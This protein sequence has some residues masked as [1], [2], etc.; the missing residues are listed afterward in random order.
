MTKRSGRAVL[1]ASGLLLQVKRSCFFVGSYTTDSCDLGQET[2]VVDTVL[3]W[4]T[5]NGGS[6]HPWEE[7]ELPAHTWTELCAE[8][9]EEGVR[10]SK[11]KGKYLKDEPPTQGQSKVSRDQVASCS[12]QRG[13]FYAWKLEKLF[14]LLKTHINCLIAKRWQ[15][16]HLRFW[17]PRTERPS[18]ISSFNDATLEFLFTGK[19]LTFMSLQAP[20]ITLNY[21]EPGLTRLLAHACTCKSPADLATSSNFGP[22]SMPS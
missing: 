3:S 21:S 7:L 5:T 15:R 13:L 22:V 18:S 10:R 6:V 9:T 12:S 14:V 20:H 2:G 1:H 16:Y 19:L 8:V 11:N 17:L 4:Y